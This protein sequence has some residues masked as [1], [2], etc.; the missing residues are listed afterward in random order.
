MS[1]KDLNNGK[2]EITPLNIES[3]VNVDSK[4]K[5]GRPKLDENIARKH[6]V[7]L[8]FKESEYLSIKD[9]AIDSGI[10]NISIYIR[11]IVLKH[12]RD[13]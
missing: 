6:K 11:Q 7:T 12:L 10:D 1:F 4:N 9:K 5:G 3:F 2:I 13:N 8:H